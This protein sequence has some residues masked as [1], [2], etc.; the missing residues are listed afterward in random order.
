MQDRLARILHNP[1]WALVA[2]G[3]RYRGEP[4]R[5]TPAAFK[6]PDRCPDRIGRHRFQRSQVRVGGAEI[7]RARPTVVDI[8][9]SF[10]ARSA[11]KNLGASGINNRATGRKLSKQTWWIMPKIREV[12]E[13]L[14][15]E[16][17]AREKLAEVNAELLFWALAGSRPMS[18]YKKT[19]QGRSERLTA[20]T[21]WYPQ[22]A[23]LYED[24]LKT[25]PRKDVSRDDILDAAAAAVSCFISGGILREI[26]TESQLDSRGL[27]MRMVFPDPR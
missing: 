13:L 19:P 14:Q 24:A 3:V 8:C 12:D 25:Y 6:N 15:S 20:L 5:P 4:V 18:H 23:T 16:R 21:R 7:P 10:T 17:P 1:R 11:R 26:P 22:T 27:P 2:R 9:G